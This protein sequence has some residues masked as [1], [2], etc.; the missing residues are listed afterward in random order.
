MVGLKHLGRTSK[1]LRRLG[2]KFRRPGLVFTG[3]R[4]TAKKR[5]CNEIETGSFRGKARAV[6]S[7]SSRIAPVG[8][9]YATNHNV[10]RNSSGRDSLEPIDRG[11]VGAS[12]A[13]AN[14]TAAGRGHGIVAGIIVTAIVAAAN[15][16][17]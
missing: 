3:Q 12:A 15:S 1:R 6:D 14:F 5:F 2:A 17:I 9:N 10:G 8:G 11:R 13:R 4:R 7:S 16:K